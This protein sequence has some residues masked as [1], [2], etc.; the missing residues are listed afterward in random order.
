MNDTRDKIDRGHNHHGLHL[1]IL[2]DWV[3]SLDELKR[4]FHRYETKASFH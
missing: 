1:S 3:I 2:T 4:G